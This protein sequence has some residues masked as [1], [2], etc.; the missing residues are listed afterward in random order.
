MIKKNLIVVL[1]VLLVLPMLN[2]QT[3]IDDTNSDITIIKCNALNYT[4]EIDAIDL[5]KI[6]VEN[7]A[8]ELFNVSSEGTNITNINQTYDAVIGFYNLTSN[9]SVYNVN[10]SAYLFNATPSNQS[11][12]VTFSAGQILRIVNITSAGAPP[13][14]PPGGEGGGSGLTPEIYGRSLGIENISIEICNL[15]YWS[16]QREYLKYVDID[17]IIQDNNISESW[18]TIRTYIDYW[19]GLCSDL[20]NK[21]LKP[22]IVCGQ[23]Y[24][25]MIEKEQNYTYQDIIKLREELKPNVTISIDLLNYYLN[26]YYELC[27]LNSYSA[28]IPKELLWTPVIKGFGI[29]K[30]SINTGWSFFDWKIHFRDPRDIKFVTNETDEKLAE[31]LDLYIGGRVISP[32]AK[33]G[34]GEL[35]CEKIDFYRWLFALEYDE[36]TDQYFI[37]GMKLW[38]VFLAL[39]ISGGVYW[40]KKKKLIKRLR[41]YIKTKKQSN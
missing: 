33:F 18:T 38:Y 12:N 25:F 40:N 27:Y 39:S 1:V 37:V 6:N 11:W 2:A 9:L 36:G 21:T 35:S 34:I 5:D 7:Y 31:N 20:T 10:T 13:I 41:L 8:I 29:E 17:K 26:N 30:C 22:R 28:K 32:V 24:L 14:T 3:I 15:T 4:I 19:Q 23:I 16:A